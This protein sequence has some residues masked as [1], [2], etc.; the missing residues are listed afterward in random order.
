MRALLVETGIDPARIV[1][2]RESRNTA[3]NARNT[4]GL[5]AARGWVKAP[6][7]LVTSAL[8]M[9]RAHATF[10]QAG[11]DACAVVVD[12]R[13]ERG[14]AWKAWIPGAGALSDSEA[15]AH[16]ILGMAA[17]RVLGHL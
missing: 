4:A 16:E 1:V 12:S 3:E 7:A 8:H 10:R 14:S 5:V 6:L 15:V 13:A 9:P 2:E 17:Y 11:L